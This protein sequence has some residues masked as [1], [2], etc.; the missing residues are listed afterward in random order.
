MQEPIEIAFQHCE[1]SEEIR[2]AIAKQAQRLEK[3]SDRIT[4]CRVVVTGPQ[5]RHRLGELFQID[6]RIAM[7]EHKDVIVGQDARRRA[8]SASMLW[9]R[10]GRLST[11]RCGRSKTRRATC[12]VKSRSTSRRTMAG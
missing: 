9:S 12:A 6:L 3:F 7:P 2:A 10:S 11:P 5:T 4:S 1:P 8:P